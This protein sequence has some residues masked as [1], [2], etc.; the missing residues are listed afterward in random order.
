L[1]FRPKE[2]KQDLIDSLDLEIDD[3]GRKSRILREEAKRK[4]QKAVDL[5]KEGFEDAAKR[6]LALH[7][8]CKQLVNGIEK[9]M[10]DLETARLQVLM[11]PERPP[12]QVLVKANDLLRKAAVE[13]ERTQQAIGKMTYFTQVNVEQAVS[14]LEGY[15]IK[16]K[17]L[18]EEFQKLKGEAGVPISKTV[19]EA[20]K[21]EKLPEVPKETSKEEEAAKKEKEAEK[22]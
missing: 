20:V 14:E 5:T 8:L 11:Q 17:I 2:N 13:G 7:L 4:H 22:G 16:E 10:A 18:D 3:H 19:E 15:G 6:W 12:S 21:E 9:T 1:I